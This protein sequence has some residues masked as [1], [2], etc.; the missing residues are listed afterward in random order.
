MA[1]D[2]FL[3]VSLEES[4]SKALAQVMSND[5]ARKILDYLSRRESATES[6][7]AK[8][9]KLALSTVHYNL[10]AL[11][12]ANLVQAE[13]FHY[14]EKG[15]E[16]LHYSLANKVIIIAPKRSSAESF[17]DKLKSLL[18][19][20]LVSLSIAGLIQLYQMLFSRAAASAGA[21]SLLFMSE[22]GPAAE[23]SARTLVQDIAPEAAP[24]MAK[25]GGDALSMAASTVNETLNETVNET[26][27]QVA[28][29]AQDIALRTTE[30][31]YVPV[32]QPPELLA[33]WFLAGSLFA[34]A[35]LALWFYFSTRKK[36]NP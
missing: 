15:K 18:P 35:F 30:V 24:M 19:V 6:D 16:V 11:V 20:G 12:K 4:E 2:P 25:V 17:K 9:L 1:K 34:I 5:T 32:Q 28:D 22:A 23:E 7:V 33:L 29:V 10:Q 13:E 21:E 8:G 36:A 27:R 31:I 3:L 26:A 14:S